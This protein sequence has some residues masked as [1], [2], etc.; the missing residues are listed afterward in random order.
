[1]TQNPPF[2]QLALIS[3]V[4]DTVTTMSSREITELTSKR[5]DNVAADIKKM[6]TELGEDVLKFQGIYLDAQ[7]RKQTEYHLNRELT[8]TLLTGYSIPLR[9]KVIARWHELEAKVAAPAFQIPTTL[10]SALMLAAQQA[11]QIEQQQAALAIAG[12]KAKALDRIAQAD[13]DMCMT[14]AAKDIGMQPH[15]LIAWLEQND[16]IYRRNGAGSHT[17]Y[18][19]RIKSGYLTHKVATVQRKDGCDKNVSQVI[20]TAK[21]LVK[22]AEV[23]A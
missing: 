4:S 20:V 8:D 9:R 16:W 19:H 6:L 12:P 17:A 10:S 1:M 7:N 13:G 14:N 21:G 5:H 3:A 18:Q 22:L 23:T 15:K 11:E 2:A